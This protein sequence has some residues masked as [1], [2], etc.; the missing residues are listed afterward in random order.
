MATVK[1]MELTPFSFSART[2][3]GPEQPTARIDIS[4]ACCT[5]KAAT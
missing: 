3:G 4:C 5:G 2:L 1:L